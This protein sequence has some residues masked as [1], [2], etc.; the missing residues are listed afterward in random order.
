M[1]PLMLALAGAVNRDH[2]ETQKFLCFFHDGLFH[3]Q[4]NRMLVI[5]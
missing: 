3:L 5:T 1:S 4:L 2:D